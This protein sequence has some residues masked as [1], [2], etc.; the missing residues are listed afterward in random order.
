M[1]TQRLVQVFGAAIGRGAG[2][3]GCAVGA[4][5]L[6]RAGLVQSL[7]AAGVRARWEATIA[8]G[9]EGGDLAA[10][11]RFSRELARPVCTSVQRNRL[12]LVVGGDHSCAIGTWS[13][14]A[15]ALRPH[16]PL[17]LVW[18]DAHMDAHVPHT[19]PS[20]N[21]HGMPLALLLGHGD[22]VLTRL[23]GAPALRPEHVCLVGVRSYE[24]GEARLLARLGVRVITM[25]EVARRGAGDCL[26]EAASIAQAGTAGFGVSLDIDSIDPLEAPGVGTPVPHGLHAAELAAGMAKIVAH[27]RLTAL[28][29][30]EYNPLRDRD[31]ETGRLV[32]GLIVDTLAAATGGRASMRLAA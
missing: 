17:G 22:H 1:R 2:D 11:R 29:V 25:E 16:G 4:E 13:G 18:I 15:S 24:E 31:G 7:S 32:S 5:A 10:V 6:R 27:P 12:P 21:L 3:E 8:P 14:V 19:S 23:A 20:G 9:R 30:V 26:A 28:E